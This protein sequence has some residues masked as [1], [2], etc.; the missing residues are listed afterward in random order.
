MFKYVH[1]DIFFSLRLPFQLVVLMNNVQYHTLQT[2]WIHIALTSRLCLL[3][4]SRNLTNIWKY[5]SGKPCF[6]YLSKLNKSNARGVYIVTK[7]PQAWN[8]NKM[9]ICQSFHK[10]YKQATKGIQYQE[11]YVIPSH[12]YPERKSLHPPR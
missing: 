2:K 8:L 10:Q 7:E 3:S 5:N 6:T 9:L 11:S 1:Y 4:G 12:M